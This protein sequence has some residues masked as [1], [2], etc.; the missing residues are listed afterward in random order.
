MLLS[1][2]AAPLMARPNIIFICSDDHARQAIS[3]YGSKLIHT[4]NI[5]RLA[6]EGTLFTR[7]YS[8]N[9]ICAPSRAA[10]LTGKYSHINGHRDNASAFN[11]AQQTF[12]KLLQAAGYETALFGKWHL[13]SNPTGFDQWAVLRGQGEYYNPLFITAEGQAKVPGYVTNIIT[14]KALTFLR[15]KHDKPFCLMIGHKAPHRNWVPDLPYLSQF[16]DRTFP[17][18][19]TM[20][21]KYDSLSSAAKKALMRMDSMTVESDLMID[22]SPA[23]LTPSQKKAWEAAMDKQDAAYKKQVS[24]TGDLL[25]ANYQRYMQD[26]LRCVQSVDD[27]IGRLLKELDQSGLAKNTIVIYTSDQGFFLGE[28]GWFD[29]RF[30][31]EPSAGTPLLIR[32]PGGKRQV[33]NRLSAD[34]DIAATLL[35]FAGVPVPAEIQ[36]QD[37]FG[38]SPHSVIYGHFYESDDPDHKVAK[39]VAATTE[40]YKVIC[41]Y[42]LKEWELF[43]LRR[44]HNEQHNLWSATPTSVQ[45]QMV[46]SLLGEM[47]RLK[48]DPSLVERVRALAA[49]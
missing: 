8:T 26:Y 23:P 43:D 32:R 46:T 45:K 4:T 40:R 49:R 39:Y 42:E 17:E 24:T 6:K 1:L 20:R 15:A 34:T 16:A 2:L 28:N 10:I 30:F 13:V 19:A 36:G 12:P 25:G 35:T 9:P 29:K 41:Y 48:E 5:D 18:P 21:T 33:T 22:N 14:D 44:D 37:L 3:A 38:P 7:Y 11:G 27:N 31:Y 47:M